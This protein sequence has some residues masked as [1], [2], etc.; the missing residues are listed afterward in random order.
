ME[1]VIPLLRASAFSKYWSA[2]IGLSSESVISRMLSRITITSDGKKTSKYESSFPS[3]ARMLTEDFMS[4]RKV[5][6]LRNLVLT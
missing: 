2:V 6:W 5:R 3:E 4:L 1:S